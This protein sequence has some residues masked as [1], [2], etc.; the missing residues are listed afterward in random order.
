MEWDEGN[1]SGDGV[2]WSEQQWWWSGMKWTTVVMEWDEVDN[3]GDRVGWSGQQW[4]QSG[5]KWTTEGDG[6]GWSNNSVLWGGI[7]SVY[8]GGNE[9]YTI[10]ILCLLLFFC[11]VGRLLFLVKWVSGNSQD[12]CKIT[13]TTPRALAALKI[14]KQAQRNTQ[15]LTAPLNT[16]SILESNTANKNQ[17]QHTRIKHSTWGIIAHLSL[18]AENI[19]K[20]EVL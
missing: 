3:N 6:E 9:C 12:D 8:L 20:I 14:G 7:N 10:S 5:M 1:N 15:W 2:G 4:W 17:T 18:Q 11:F 16:I 13:K 19:L